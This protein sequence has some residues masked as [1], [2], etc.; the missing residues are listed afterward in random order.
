MNALFASSVV[1][2]IAACVRTANLIK[3]HRLDDP[4]W[5]VLATMFL[6]VMRA[7]FLTGFRRNG[8][9]ANAAAMAVRFRLLFPS[10]LAYVLTTVSRS[11]EWSFGI[12]LSCLPTLRSVWRLSR[13]RSVSGTQSQHRLLS[14]QD[15]PRW[16]WA[17]GNVAARL[18]PNRDVRPEIVSC[19]V[20]ERPKNVYRGGRGLDEE[21]LDAWMK[22]RKGIF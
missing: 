12:I 6:F 18:R 22:V 17:V 7:L 14:A 2:V 1:V 10:Q 15:L 19:E 8:M 3:V 11:Q 4:T 13:N 5:Y 20:L 9:N 16:S 21:R